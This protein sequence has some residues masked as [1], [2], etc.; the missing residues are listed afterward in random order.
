MATLTHLETITS[1]TSGTTLTSSSHALVPGESLIVAINSV[2]T[3]GPPTTVLHNGRT[4]RRRINNANA[5]NTLHL[6]GWVK[7]EYNQ[8]QTGVV[9]ATWSVAIVERVMSVWKLNISINEEATAIKDETTATVTPGTGH[10]GALITAG[11]FVVGQRYEIDTPGTTDF[12]LIGAANSNAG[13]LFTATGIGSGTGTARE[14]LSVTNAFAI[15]MFGARGPGNDATGTMQFDLSGTDATTWTAATVENGGGTAGAPP[16]SNVTVRVGGIQL[17]DEESVR[18]RISAY[19]TA[20]TWAT[21]ILVVR[22]RTSSL[23]RQGITPTDTGAVE[24][25]VSGAGGVTEDILYGI[26]EDTGLWEAFEVAS[27]GTAVA[28]R[29]E[30]G[31]WS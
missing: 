10:T 2:D 9:R 7:G 6:S 28:T 21:G 13:T 5:T 18:S 25:I 17:T 30:A 26:N 24:Q 31:A 29:D 23:I 4:L 8:N 27:P 3:A 22:A 19:G 15:G 12:T 20:R 11:S 16:V 1:K 14:A